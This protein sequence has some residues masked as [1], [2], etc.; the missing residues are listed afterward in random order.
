M[1]REELR[2]LQLERMKWCVQ[3][4]Y[5]N[6]PFLSKELK[7]AGVEPGDLKTLEDI[8]EVPVYPQAGHAR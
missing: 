4:A 6:V 5:D 2:D 1:S 7:D 8:H 3:Y